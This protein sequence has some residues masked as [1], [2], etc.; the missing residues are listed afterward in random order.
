MLAAYR[1][2][3]SFLLSRH[4]ELRA[5]LLWS[6]IFLLHHSIR[7]LPCS[8]FAVVII[9]FLRDSL[10]ALFIHFAERLVDVVNLILTG[11]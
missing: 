7:P 1:A 5:V 6:S 2:V 10:L 8:K 3:C 9:E 4:V 11:N